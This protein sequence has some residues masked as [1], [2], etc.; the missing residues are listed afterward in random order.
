MGNGVPFLYINN[1]DAKFPVDSNVFSKDLLWD[2]FSICR[3]ASD[4]FNTSQTAHNLW[5]VSLS[6]EET[7]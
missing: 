6:L 3:F 2:N 4:S 5:N 7:F 1:V